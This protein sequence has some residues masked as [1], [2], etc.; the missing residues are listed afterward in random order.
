MKRV[1]LLVLVLALGTVAEIAQ[2]DFTWVQKADMPTPRW[3]QTSAVVNGKI[4]VIGG[5]TS[6]PGEIALSTVEE[7][8]PVT[9]TWMRKAD[10]P[11]VRCDMV[12]SSAVVDD[13][14]YVIG[15]YSG[16]DSCGGTTVEEYD[17]V[18]DTWTRKADMPTRRWSLATCAMDG[19]IY[20]IGGAPSSC[21]PTGLNI[22]E[23]YD[24]ITD[25]WTR[26]ANI[27]TGLWGLCTN[28]VNG[29]IYT[30]GGRPGMTAVPNTY[31][32]DP[33]TDTWTRKAD[34]PV[35]TS[36]MGSVVLGDKIIV[37]GG[38]LWSM[39]DPY[40]TVQ[41]YDPQ[42][43]TWTIEADVPF[44]RAVFSADV[45][46]NRIYAI[47]GTYK[48]H[49]C[50][51]TSTV[52]ELTINPPP[53]DFN[54]DGII[55]SEDMW[56]MYNHLGEDHS[57]CDIAPPPF[58]DGIVDGQDLIAL[59]GYLFPDLVARWRLDE[60]TGNI[61]HDSIAGNNGTCHGGPV[62]GPDIGKVGGALTFDGAEDYVS[63]PFILDPAKVAFSVFVW[64][65]G[66]AT[67]QVILSQADTI[68]PRATIP[69]STWL[70]IDPSEGKLMTGLSDVYFG[71]LES[72]TLITDLQWHHVGL[73][74]DLD[75]L[76]RRLYIDGVL[77]AE[78][79]TVVSGVPSDGG[80]HIGTGRDLDPASFF[81][82]MIDDVRIY[83][84]A[85]NDE[86][87]EALAK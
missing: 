24:P 63:T 16:G 44:Q 45:V 17:P 39:N 76:H 36:Q 81:L 4:Y 75:S 21:S 65:Y 18:T 56:I 20:A 84:V 52:Y 37:I 51:A 13:K 53:P 68:Q 78:D 60:E 58:G 69:G 2:A 82:G 10:M 32:Y 72:E 30:I 61:A 3:T 73:V 50:P 80:L 14:I 83:D 77:A 54:G 11:T 41:M 74:Y 35:A 33:S 67:G 46:N 70:G 31:E 87:V 79:A 71:A 40:T 12:G 43:D 27:P 34:I 55:D 62:W 66:G 38:W 29:K 9:D 42:T 86:E 26:K 22:V 28:V 7:Y 25:T 1:M 15:G 59:A 19:K 6:Q 85:L 48:R 64:I 49:P 47:G 5:L 57:L 8:D 23:Q